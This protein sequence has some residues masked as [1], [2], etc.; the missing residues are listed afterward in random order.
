MSRARRRLNP[1]RRL[2]DVP[3]EVR[4]WWQRHQRRTRAKWS[5]LDA[6]D[7]V[8]YESITAAGQIDDE[9]MWPVWRDWQLDRGMAWPCLVDQDQRVRAPR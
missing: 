4:A 1:T 2:G 8:G 3:A 5:A 9:A 6:G 7:R